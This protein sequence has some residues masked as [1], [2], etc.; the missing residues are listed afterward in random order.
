MQGLIEKGHGHSAALV[1][2]G[3]FGAV[4]GA[5]SIFVTSEPSVLPLFVGLLLGVAGLFFFSWLL[6]NFSRWFGGQ[7][8]LRHVRTAV[9]IALLPW[10]VLF[11]LFFLFAQS[12]EDPAMLAELFPIFFA[13]FLYGFVILLLSL[14]AALKLTVLKTFICLT[15]AVLVCVF[16]LTWLAQVFERLFA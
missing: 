7:P 6:R 14:S 16:P 2:A 5:P 12:V 13:G 4:Q 3:L 15:V 10:T 9:G 1:A 8:E 11:G